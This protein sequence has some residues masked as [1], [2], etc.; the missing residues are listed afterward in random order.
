MLEQ[1]KCWPRWEGEE[2]EGKEAGNV[3]YKFWKLFRVY[4]VVK[5]YEY[6]MY[7]FSYQTKAGEREIDLVD[8]EV[9]RQ[10][11]KKMQACGLC[12]GC[13][14]NMGNCGVC[15]QCKNPAWKQKCERRQ[16]SGMEHRWS[17]KELRGNTT[18]L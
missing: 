9:K 3:G 2:N 7:T 16:C 12:D 4:C 17:K 1:I 13:R 6:G 8:Q 15:R 18:F 10:N 14:N 11:Q 5:R